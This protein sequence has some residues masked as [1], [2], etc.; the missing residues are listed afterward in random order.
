MATKQKDT[1]NNLDMSRVKSSINSISKKN[2]SAD[3][4]NPIVAK[5]DHTENLVSRKIS[6][7]ASGIT[8]IKN[9]SKQNIAAV[10][11]LKKTVD[12]VNSSVHN[13]YIKLEEIQKKLGGKLESIDKKLVS[14]GAQLDTSIKDNASI[15]PPSSNNTETSEDT[16]NKKKPDGPG[17]LE[18]VGAVSIL[19]GGIKSVGRG[20][21]AVAKKGGAILAVASEAYSALNEKKRNDAMVATGQMTKEEGS[22]ANKAALGA[23]VGGVGGAAIGA[24][25]GETIG[26]TVGSIVPGAGTVV[27]GVLGGIAGGYI[28][29]KVGEDFGRSSVN[30]ITNPNPTQRADNTKIKITQTSK[31]VSSLQLSDIIEKYVA[32]KE[33]VRMK[34]YADSLGKGTIGVGHLITKEEMNQGFIKAG[35][36]KIVIQPNLTDTEG[37]PAQIRDLF[38]QDIKVKEDSVSSS[39]GGLYSKLSETQKAALVSYAYNHG[40]I[41]DLIRKGLKDAIEDGDYRKAAD[42]IASGVTMGL[43]ALKARRLEEANLF[44]NGQVDSKKNAKE[45]G[46]GYLA[47]GTKLKKGDFIGSMETEI[48]SGPNKGKHLIGKTTKNED[49]FRE[50]PKDISSNQQQARNLTGVN[51]NSKTVKNVQ[52]KQTDSQTKIAAGAKAETPPIIAP[53]PSESLVSSDISSRITKDQ[54]SSN[55]AT[56]VKKNDIP[57]TSRIDETNSMNKADKAIQPIIIPVGNQQAQRPQ[58]MSPAQDLT[59]S[60]IPDNPRNYNSMLATIQMAEA[61]KIL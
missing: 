39:L 23:G 17:A 3:I 37:T 20:L 56:P 30:T 8:F 2:T 59:T 52:Q 34:A 25:I 9:V 24:G 57:T 58:V 14:L 53:A 32:Q 44:L 61:R 5:L 40:S 46:N 47:D 28:G 7:I 13:T 33:G 49:V 60:N 31:G 15:A 22:R 35:S 6:M 54:Y 36:S 41:T 50:N 43:P 19:K 27:G 51:E 29:G 45:D 55:N 11:L 38:K 48:H 21:G 16:K 12:N 26:A 18:T 4:L 10:E 42:I 1:D